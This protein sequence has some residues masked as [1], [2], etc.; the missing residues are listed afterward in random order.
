M[1]AHGGTFTA[2]LHGCRCCEMRVTRM[3][4]SGVP[5]FGEGGA[6][7]RVWSDCAHGAAM[8]A[9]EVAACAWGRRGRCP[10]GCGVMFDL[11]LEPHACVT[12]RKHGGR[13]QLHERATFTVT[14]SHAL[15]LS[16][17]T[18]AV[19]RHAPSASDPCFRSIAAA[20]TGGRGDGGPLPALSHIP[21]HIPCTA[22]T[23][24]PH[25]PLG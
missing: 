7:R 23:Q 5:L 13:R 3:R 24:T 22:L 8:H 25:S 21:S 14:P 2:G 1:G 4:R 12:G 15:Q 16:S 19:R 11:F 20:G 6:D 9:E 18:H 10:P 17:I